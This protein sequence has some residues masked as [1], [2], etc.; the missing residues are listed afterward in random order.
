MG[1]ITA[2]SLAAGVSVVVKNVPL[3]GGAG[4]L[5]RKIALFATPAAANVSNVNLN[6]PTL[7]LG[8]DEVGAKA[9]MGSM[10][11]RLA[12]AAFRGSDRSIPIYMCYSAEAAG[13]VAASWRITYTGT[14]TQSGSHFL[15]IAGKLY[16]IP[17]IMN[18][19]PTVIGQRA[20]NAITADPECPVSAVN[21]SGAV[22]L[23]A[24][25]KGAWGNGIT[26]TQNQRPAE[27]QSLPAGLTS[28]I[29]TVAAGSLN[30]DMAAALRSTLGDGDSAN[31]Q[32][33]TDV[34]HGYGQDAT[35]LDA[36]ADYVGRG[37][38]FTGLYSGTVARPFRSA[39]GDT[40]TGSA[41]LS[42]LKTFTDGRPTDRTNSVVSKPGSLTH[43]AEIA[44]EYMGV[45]ARINND[46][47]EAS[48]EG[49]ILSG[50]DPGIMARAAG[51]DWTT[52]YTNRDLAVKAGISPL[53]VEDGAVKITNAVSVYH[54]SSIPIEN[55][56]YRRM[57]DL[58]ITQNILYNLK[59]TFM[60]E[61]WLGFTVVKDKAFVQDANARRYARD[62]GDVRGELLTQFNSFVSLGWLFSIDAVITSLKKPGAIALRPDGSGFNMYPECVYS[63]EGLIKVI[64]T[65]ID[66]RVA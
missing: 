42:A 20:V 26:I 43:P 65:A 4:V 2:G 45:L 55:N 52:D 25:S 22:T 13:A 63:G 66:T 3:S 33:F 10:A 19:T 8:P 34:I 41:G 16:Q 48:P 28:T 31:E 40:A 49:L 35:V 32:T 12:L 53:T 1:N 29:T 58:S 5:S 7:V 36:L 54:P 37:N 64:N 15:Y 27:D 50:V 11:H 23:T 17:V 9:G 44:A 62:I 24:K 46:R 57:R 60:S 61:K 18:D 47:A 21:V 56:A 30:P 59:R 39:W 38:D 51:D 6:T 14:P